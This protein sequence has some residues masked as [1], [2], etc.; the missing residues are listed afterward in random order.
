MALARAVGVRF[1]RAVR[2]LARR[3]ARAQVLLA[4]V[5][6]SPDDSAL[7]GAVLFPCPR[8]EPRAMTRGDALASPRRGNP[9]RG[10]SPPLF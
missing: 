8:P 5:Y 9:S 10:R 2:F 3:G 7:S 4:A 6:I 1:P